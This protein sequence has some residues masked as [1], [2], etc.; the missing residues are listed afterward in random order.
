MFGLS[1]DKRLFLQYNLHRTNVPNGCP[2]VSVKERMRVM[3]NRRSF[4]IMDDR[5][6]RSYRRVLRLRR[7]RRQKLVLG[8][9]AVF[10]AICMVLI[11]SLS[12]RA[13]KSNASSGFKY[14]TS[15]TVNTGDT[16]WNIADEYIDYDFYKNKNS[17]ISEVKHI[18]HLE[19]DTISA[20]QTLVVP[21]YSSE[22]IY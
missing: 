21:Y 15:I 19:E 3:Q 18:N 1:V 13:I 10:A 17:Y 5:A 22:Y 11:C 20:G 7:A 16:L 12:Y 6:L 14:Y 4:E 2:D 8:F 9:V